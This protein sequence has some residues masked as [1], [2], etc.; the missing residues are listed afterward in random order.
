MTEQPV[1]G[2]TTA[3]YAAVVSTIALFLACGSF[4]VSKLSYDL[5]FTKDQREI[6][7]KMPAIDIQV[8]PTSVN[9]AFLGL[10]TP[11]CP[12]KRQKIVVGQE[13]YVLQEFAGKLSRPSDSA[14]GPRRIHSLPS[15]SWRHAHDAFGDQ[16]R[17]HDRMRLTTAG[18]AAAE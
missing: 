1:K 2:F 10:L 12:Q 13:I 6:R 14:F 8:R 9:A 5:S 7:D 11:N 17:L 18:N 4:Y 16:R 15:N 3:R